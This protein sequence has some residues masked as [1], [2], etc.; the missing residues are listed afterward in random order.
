MIYELNIS[1][2]F[3]IAIDLVKFNLVLKLRYYKLD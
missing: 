2:V 1:G 3:E